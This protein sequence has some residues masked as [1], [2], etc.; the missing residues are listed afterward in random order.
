M[1]LNENNDY[2]EGS[3]EFAGK[4][5]GEVEEAFEIC[6]ES[7]R[8]WH[9]LEMKMA[10]AEHSAI[11]NED[12][13]L[14]EAA[15]GDFFAKAKQWFITLGKKIKEFFK[16]LVERIGV[17]FMG[18]KKF[19]AKY[20]KQL[21]ALGNNE[22]KGVVKMFPKVA[23]GGVD[24]GASILVQ[25]AASVSDAEISDEKKTAED[26]KLPTSEAISDAILGGAKA[27]E[28]LTSTIVK[29]ALNILK[30]E[31]TVTKGLQTAKKACDDAIKDGIKACDDAK[32]GSV[33]DE[34]SK[35]NNK[36]SNYKV[37]SAA[38]NS[39]LGQMGGAYSKL[40]SN[41]L[42]VCKSAWNSR[43]GT[44]IKQKGYDESASILDQF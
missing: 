21:A 22:I 13:P 18:A 1:F 30:E 36:I 14:M 38:C 4:Y 11:V 37:L 33:D 7:E 42:S 26:F 34:T 12:A 35:L 28:T 41:A 23:N 6:L 40:A 5:T 32:K 17:F 10:R 29:N 16:R 24:T 44:N 2:L 3:N 20:G 9:Q 31:S 19:V 15:V 27:E 8:E 39:A 25:K 43:K